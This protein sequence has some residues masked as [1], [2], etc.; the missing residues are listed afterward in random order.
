ML[1]FHAVTHAITPRSV[2]RERWVTNLINCAALIVSSSNDFKHAVVAV[3]AEQRRSARAY[4]Q[5][6]A[7][8]DEKEMLGVTRGSRT[9]WVRKSAQ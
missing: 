1:S 2:A 7:E 4:S 9:S 8:E 3:V 5:R 6:D